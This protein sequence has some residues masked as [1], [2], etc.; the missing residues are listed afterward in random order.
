VIRLAAVAERQVAELFGQFGRLERPEAARNLMTA[1]GQGDW[2][3]LA[4]PN[5]GFASA[6]TLSHACPTRSG[7]G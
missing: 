6:E 2:A 5:R 7:M 1:L 4:R 3:D